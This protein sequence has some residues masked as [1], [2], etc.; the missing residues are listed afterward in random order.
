MGGGPQADL[1]LISHQ[2]LRVF[3]HLPPIVDK[4]INVISSHRWELSDTARDFRKEKYQVCVS[5]RD[6]MHRN[7]PAHNPVATVHSRCLSCSHAQ[8]S[9]P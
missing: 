3:S 8:G 9:T 7:L 2:W 6:G 4:N 1:A 5:D